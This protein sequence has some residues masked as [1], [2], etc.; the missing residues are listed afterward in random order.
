MKVPYPITKSKFS[1]FSLLMIE[2]TVIDRVFYSKGKIKKKFFEKL[3]N[4]LTEKP[5][6]YSKKKLF[7]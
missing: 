2:I 5:T 6:Q 3:T 4:I 1:P 7:I